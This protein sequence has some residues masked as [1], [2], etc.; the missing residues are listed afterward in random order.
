MQ[1]F[2]A[3][4]AVFILFGGLLLPQGELILAAPAAMFGVGL[5]LR[6][7][8]RVVPVIHWAMV[9]VPGVFGLLT[10]HRAYVEPL[11]EYGEEGPNPGKWTRGFHQDAIVSVANPAASKAFGER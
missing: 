1:L 4:V 2:R 5:I 6:E 9:F 3:V 10:I 8:L 7:V 11:S